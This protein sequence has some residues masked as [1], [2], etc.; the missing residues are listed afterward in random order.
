MGPIQGS[1]RFGEIVPLPQESRE[2]ETL[3]QAMQHRDLRLGACLL[4]TVDAFRNSV[5]WAPVIAAA[6]AARA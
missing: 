2:S 5:R 1:A 4:D 6:E 3:G